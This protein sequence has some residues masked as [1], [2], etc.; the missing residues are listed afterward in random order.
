MKNVERLAS[1]ITRHGGKNTL[2]H[3]I[4]GS[5]LWLVA[6]KIENN[7]WA[8][9]LMDPLGNITYNLGVIDNARHKALWKHLI[10]LE[11]EQRTT[12]LLLARQLQETIKYFSA[13][14]GHTKTKY[15]KFTALT[16]SSRS[17]PLRHARL[18]ILKQ[19]RKPSH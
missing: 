14:S 3:T 2:V 11:I 9:T 4:P 15:K 8:V 19:L 17:R 1:H 13:S 18:R 12:A 6:Q 5:S 16:A 10:A 7:N